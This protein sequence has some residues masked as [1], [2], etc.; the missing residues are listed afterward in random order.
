MNYDVIGALMKYF[1][2]LETGSSYTVLFFFCLL[3]LINW[4]AAK[5]EN[6][7]LI[8]CY[9]C[10]QYTVL[11]AKSQASTLIIFFTSGNSSFIQTIRISIWK[12]QVFSVEL[13]RKCWFKSRQH[14]PECQLSLITQDWVLK[15]SIKNILLYYCISSN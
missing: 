11:C 14:F 2:W 5:N 7:G 6:T 15:I 10:F 13:A 9:C 8:C 4:S 12:F 1:A 3:I